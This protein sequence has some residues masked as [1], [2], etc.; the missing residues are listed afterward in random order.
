MNKSKIVFVAV[1]LSL[2]IV[3]SFALW[4][5]HQ[6][7]TLKT[8][9][10]I[11]SFRH[12]RETI[13]SNLR[14]QIVGL[15]KKIVNLP[16]IFTKNKRLVLVEKI[17]SNF[18]SE[19]SEKIADKE[20]ITK[21]FSRDERKELFSG[22]I[23]VQ[24]ANNKLYYAV[25]LMDEN[26]EFTGVVERIQ[27]QSK[28]V[29]ADF[30]KVTSI[31]NSEIT[32]D[33]NKI[34]YEEKIALLKQICIDSAFEAEKTRLEF[35]SKERDVTQ[36][37]KKFIQATQGYNQE[38]LQAVLAVLG[39][40]VLCALILALWSSRRKNPEKP[41]APLSVKGVPNRLSKMAVEGVKRG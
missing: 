14:A 26:G 37:N 12:E 17:N 19:S 27:L 40:N 8:L 24:T 7:N 28:N 33:N 41:T 5:Y 29:N 13:D 15:Q 25:G 1:T 31:V 23:I 4:H 38:W 30:E 11:D 18:T 22:R 35:V 9:Q 39:A 32:E 6:A 2:Y 36:I 34:N 3:S 16:K 20:V 10:E 21:F